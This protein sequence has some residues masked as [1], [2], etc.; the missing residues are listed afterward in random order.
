MISSICFPS[1]PPVLGLKFRVEEEGEVGKVERE[2]ERER[3]P[4]LFQTAKARASSRRTEKE[5]EAD[6]VRPPDRAA[7]SVV[8]R[9]AER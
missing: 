3:V 6:P 7:V 1:A 4:K 8:P 9:P 5:H 2:R